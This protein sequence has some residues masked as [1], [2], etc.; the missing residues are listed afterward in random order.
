MKNFHEKE[1]TELL[2]KNNNLLEN[3]DSIKSEFQK[4]V[5]YKLHKISELQTQVEECHKKNQLGLTLIEEENHMK[6][7]KIINDKDNELKIVY[8]K[9]KEQ[10]EINQRL[11]RE[12]NEKT[13]LIQEIKYKYHERFNELDYNICQNE[14][15]FINMKHFYEEKIGY[16][17]S[18]YND[19]K[20]NI[21]EKYEENIQ[22]LLE[23]YI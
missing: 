6:I 13:N 22:K 12:L 18:H 23:I 3:I 15:E 8:N 7:K 16:L 1:K 21:I 10:E 19:E 9:L 5:F 11:M 20:H 17:E 4:Q 2:R 14:K